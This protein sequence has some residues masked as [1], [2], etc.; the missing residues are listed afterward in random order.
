MC[1]RDSI[2]TAQKKIGIAKYEYDKLAKFAKSGTVS[3]SELMMAKYTLEIAELEL[4]AA[5]AKAEAFREMDS[6]ENSSKIADL[7]MKQVPLKA[8]IKAGEEMLTNINESV[9]LSN[10]LKSVESEKRLLD[11]DLEMVAAQLSK[12]TFEMQE[13]GIL[14]KM[15]QLKVGANAKSDSATSDE[16]AKGKANDKD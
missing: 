16:K 7:R 8:R 6:A 1:I 9:K 2:Q 15:I 11:K 12:N 10:Q 4:M 13:L 3:Q 5:E 14:R